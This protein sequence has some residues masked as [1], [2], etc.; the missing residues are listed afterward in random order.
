MKALFP[1]KLYKVAIADDGDAERVAKEKPP[2][3][4]YGL[5]LRSNFSWNLVGNVV[6]AVCQWGILVVIAKL[7]NPEMVGRFA[8]ALALTAP[9]VMFTNLQLRSVQ[10]TDS[11]NEYTFADYLGLRLLCSL[12]AMFAIVCIT[13]LGNYAQDAVIVIIIIGLSK[14]VESIS[15]IFHGL[16]QR[17]E[18]MD[19]TAIAKCIK[20]GLSLCVLAIGL[21][22][23]GLVLGAL[24][25]LVGW[26]IVLLT[27]ETKVGTSVLKQYEGAGAQT[28]CLKMDIRKIRK[29]SW[30][31]LPLGFSSLI[32]SLNENVPRLFIANELGETELGI[33]AAMAYI[34]VAGTTVVRALTFAA[35]PRLASIYTAMDH[36]AYAKLL[37]KLTTFGGLLGLLGLSIAFFFGQ[38]ILSHIYSPEYA[39]YAEI[40][41]WLMGA[42]MMHYIAMFVES[43]LVVVRRLRGVMFLAVLVLIITSVACFFLVPQYKLLGAAWAVGIG[44]SIHA[45]STIILMIYSIKRN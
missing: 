17:Y 14:V 15:D 40:F 37:I 4:P 21:H 20:G 23:G 22:F 29:L 16:L 36:A 18:H 34:E 8:L 5:S 32:L 38:K 30:L 28:I 7:T 6:Y 27:Y 39:K 13:L 19:K 41:T 10:A 31:T 3:R 25:L 2:S 35:A 9:V 44:A 43:G 33:Y 12:G 42:S 24:G 1:L 45:I 26:L 11:R